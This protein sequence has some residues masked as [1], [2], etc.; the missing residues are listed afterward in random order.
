[1]IW[2][3]DPEKEMQELPTSAVFEVKLELIIFSL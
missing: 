2:I 1:V 3:A